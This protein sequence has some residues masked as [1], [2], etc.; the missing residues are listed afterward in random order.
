MQV[1]PAQTMDIEPTAFALGLSHAAVAST[2]MVTVTGVGGSA[3]VSNRKSLEA[4]RKAIDHALGE[5]EAVPAAPISPRFFLPQQPVVVREGISRFQ[6]NALVQ[7]LYDWA[8]VRGH[9]LTELALVDAPD[10]HRQQFAQLIGYSID[11]YGELSYVD[12]QAFER[13]AAAERDAKL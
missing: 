2:L 5:S 9:G 13:A 11:G 1:D 10:S 4:L 8:Q 6:S 7:H 12:E 3:T